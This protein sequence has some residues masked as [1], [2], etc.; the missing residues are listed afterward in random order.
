VVTPR[1]LDV[2]GAGNL[3]GDVAAAADVDV[4]ITRPVAEG[5]QPTKEAS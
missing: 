5:R 2:L 4:K 1:Q 3:L